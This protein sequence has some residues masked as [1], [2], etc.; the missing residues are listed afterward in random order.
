MLAT[1]VRIGI[2]TMEWTEPEQG[3][4]YWFCDQGARGEQLFSFPGAVDARTGGP[5]CPGLV[6]PVPYLPQVVRS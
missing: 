5:L 4:E 1:C 6:D 3:W 2:L